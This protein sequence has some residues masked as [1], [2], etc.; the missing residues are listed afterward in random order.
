MNFSVVQNLNINT[1]KS[2]LLNIARGLVSTYYRE[3]NPKEDF[4]VCEHEDQSPPGC[5]RGRQFKIGAQEAAK[6]QGG[7][8][9]L[10]RGPHT[11]GQ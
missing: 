10:R 4:L 2:H 3:V 11:D 9:I 7:Q 6:R 8:A 5:C 1:V